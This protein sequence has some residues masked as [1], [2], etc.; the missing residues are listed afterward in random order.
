VHRVLR[1]LSRGY[2]A[3][4][5]HPRCGRACGGRSGRELEK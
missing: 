3:S 4:G 1:P 5:S 2:D